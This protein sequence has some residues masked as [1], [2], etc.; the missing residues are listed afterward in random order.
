[1]AIFTDNDFDRLD[2]NILRHSAVSL[3]MKQQLLE[4]ALSW[5][6]SEKYKIHKIDCS[7]WKKFKFQ[8]SKALNFLENFGCAE[9]TGNL[10]ALNDAFSSLNISND[11]GTVFCFDGYHHLNKFDQRTANIILD[12]LGRASRDNLLYGKRLI[13][14]VQSDDPHISFPVIGGTA[15]MWNEKEWLN[16]SRGI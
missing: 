13:A 3:Y 12:I 9:W 10:D 8:M 15:A 14:L 5:F 16:S 2:W 11:A 6:K 7:E 4:D 1:M